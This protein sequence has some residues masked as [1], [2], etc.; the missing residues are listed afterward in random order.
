[1]VYESEDV[2]GGELGDFKSFVGKVK[3]GV[4][5]LRSFVQKVRGKAGAARG[6]G[7]V[8]VEQPAP[9]AIPPGPGA[10]VGGL[11]RNPMVLAGAGVVALL[12]LTRRR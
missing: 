5:K 11:L 9:S 12:L 2:I 8:V 1:M 4:K 10:A 3:K 7:Q 6:G